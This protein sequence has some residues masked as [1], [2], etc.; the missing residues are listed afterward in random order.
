M[1]VRLLVDS[2]EIPLNEFVEKILGGTVK[3]AVESLRGI[4]GSWESI[5]IEVDK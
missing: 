2:K 5:V 1:K 3:G 4:D